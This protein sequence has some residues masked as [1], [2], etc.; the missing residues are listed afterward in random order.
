MRIVKTAMAISL[1]F[2]FCLSGMNFAV[3]EDGDWNIEFVGTDK[4]EGEKYYTEY[5]MDTKYEGSYSLNVVYPEK[6][7]AGNY[8]E[9]STTVPGTL[10]SGEYEFKFY[11]NKENGGCSNNTS[12]VQ[13]AGKS[14]LFKDFNTANIDVA[15][16]PSGE[17][18]WI[19]FSTNITL[20]ETEN[21]SLKFVFVGPVVGC[22][23][24]EVSLGINGGENLLAC[25]GFEKVVEKNEVYIP[26][27]YTPTNIMT[28]PT[29]EGG[30]ALSWRNPECETVQNIMLYNITD[31]MLLSDDFSRNSKEINEYIIEGLST[32]KKYMFKII[33]QYSDI[34]DMEYFISG[35]AI[36]AKVSHELGTIGSWKIANFHENDTHPYSF[37]TALVDT[38]ESYEKGASLKLVSNSNGYLPGVY[39]TLTVPVSLIEGEDYQLRFNIKSE[40]TLRNLRI[41]FPG[42]EYFTYGVEGDNSYISNTKDTYDWKEIILKKENVG[43]AITSMY[44]IQDGPSDGIWID[45][46]ELKLLDENG[47]PIGDNLIE[48]GGFEGL[49]SEKAG[50]LVD[51]KV[52]EK[53]GKVNFEWESAGEVDKVRIYQQVGENWAFRGEV[54]ES[55]LA[56]DFTDLK[57]QTD[58]TFK[59]VPINSDGFEGTEKLISFKT[60]APDYLIDEPILYK[61]GK[62]SDGI[63]PGEDYTVRTSVKNNVYTDG[64]EYEF[65]VGVFKDD[66]LYELK[67]VKKIID[68]IPANSTKTP[69]NL[70]VSIPP[71]EAEYSIKVYHINST[72]EWGVLTPHKTFN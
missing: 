39:S 40:N 30:L 43:S 72:S 45:N 69:V 35:E 27:V 61:G 2:I 18:N 13:I 52:T 46:I 7:K 31:N 20:E 42:A 64:M 10:E 58:Y 26:D 66:M 51:L 32:D 71:E 19:C 6:E 70:S 57:Y 55:F 68:C 4:P 15:N 48:N 1:V 41:K 53:D 12:K 38:K 23:I 29:T 59:F 54:F 56:V 65:V 14:V 28:V 21:A 63:L 5:S 9:I 33:Y 47:E 62:V 25:G 24:D 44:F 11:M 16:V 17:D 49:I 50:A 37:H 8:L 34:P 3:A 36:G 67:S 22:Y 60:T